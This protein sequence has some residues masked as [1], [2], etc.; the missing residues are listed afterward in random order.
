MRS[1]TG[2]FLR[3]LLDCAGADL[4]FDPHR[5]LSALRL[6]LFYT[7]KAATRLQELTEG[8]AKRS[9]TSSAGTPS[10]AFVVTLPPLLGAYSCHLH[11]AVSHSR[12]QSRS[13]PSP[14]LPQ[15]TLHGAPTYPSLGAPTYPRN[16]N[17][18]NGGSGGSG[19]PPT[20]GLPNGHRST[21]L[22][23]PNSQSQQEFPTAPSQN[24]PYQAYHLPPA[25]SPPAAPTSVPAAAAAPNPHHPQAPDP[26][27]L[28]LPMLNPSPSLP[29]PS[30]RSYSPYRPSTT[31]LPTAG[32]PSPWAF[33][34]FGIPSLSPHYERDNPFGSASLREDPMA[35]AGDGAA[36]NWMDLGGGGWGAAGGA[37]GKS[38]VYGAAGGDGDEWM[39]SGGDAQWVNGGRGQLGGSNDWGAQG[40]AAGGGGGGAGW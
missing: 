10:R 14:F 23:M 38:D 31:S 37:G 8:K 27:S 30:A 26:L 32:Y 1:W 13:P 12:A 7:P 6:A 21:G 15:P 24:A 34:P 19:A 40:G 29:S 5:F 33:S 17:D 18:N 9:R 20:Q 2:A 4:L 25:V 3:Y 11:R 39:Q 35:M 28:S 22:A 16:N 36:Q